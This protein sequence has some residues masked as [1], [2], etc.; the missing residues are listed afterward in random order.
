MFVVVAAL[1]AGAFFFPYESDD[2][3]YAKHQKKPPAKQADAKQQPDNPREVDAKGSAAEAQL[4]VSDL[5]AN[6]SNGGGGSRD[7]IDPGAA[8][9][10]DEQIRLAEKQV[11]SQNGGFGDDER[12]DGTWVQIFDAKAVTRAG[13]ATPSTQPSV[14]TPANP[15]TLTLH[16]DG[17]FSEHLLL[18]MDDELIAADRANFT[19][20]YALQGFTLSVIRTDAAA[21]QAATGTRKL[22][23]VICPLGTESANGLPA[24][25]FVDGKVLKYQPAPDKKQSAEAK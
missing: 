14:T 20:R 18:S 23:Y 24:R 1:L 25:L 22:D 16:A 8:A 10:I 21:R 17:T 4:A 3:Y 2:D 12:L 19:G 13:G 6:H 5:T 9:P 11:A 15:A 7:L